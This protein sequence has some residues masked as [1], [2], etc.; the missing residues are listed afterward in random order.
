MKP[1]A[2]DN[3]RNRKCWWWN[4]RCEEGCGKP[5]PPSKAFIRQWCDKQGGKKDGREEE[6]KDL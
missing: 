6:G 3:C 1:V 4:P 5:T 2:P